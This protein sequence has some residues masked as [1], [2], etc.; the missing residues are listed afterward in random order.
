MRDNNGSGKS[1]Y[2]III[3]VIAACCVLTGIVRHFFGTFAFGKSSKASSEKYEMNGVEKMDI[4]VDFGE[5]LFQQGDEFNVSY[6][7]KGTEAPSVEQK[8]DTVVIRQNSKKDF[9]N[10][11]VGCDLIITIPKN[12]KFDEIEVK[13]SLGN[14]KV[15]NVAAKKVKLNANLGDVELTNAQIKDLT[16]SASLG[17]V[18]LKKTEADDV[19]IDA[20]LGNVSLNGSY[21]NVNV[22]ASLGNITVDNSDDSCEYDLEVD[23]GNLIVNGQKY[24]REYSN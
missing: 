18:E 23:M 16:I 22:D 10:G 20:S 9:A 4:D 5:I 19:D 24:D 17:D 15:Q 7:Y 12:A 2:L 8:G 11:R 14:V 13:D 3:C 6:N 21:K 1:T